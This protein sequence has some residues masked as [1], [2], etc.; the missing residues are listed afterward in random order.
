MVK[1]NRLLASVV[2]S[3]FGLVVAAQP[4]M[5]PQGPVNEFSAIEGTSVLNY[6]MRP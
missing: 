5:R 1:T 6:N 3:L 4:G 2:F